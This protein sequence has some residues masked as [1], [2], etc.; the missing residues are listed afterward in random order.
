MKKNDGFTLVEL[1]LA[2][3]F[4][5]FILLFVTTGFVMVNRAYTKGLTVKQIQDE[6][7]RVME[8]LTRKV[9]V[10]SSEGINIFPSEDCIE[11]SGTIY[12][13]SIPIDSG[14]TESPSRLYEEDGG[15]CSS[16]NPANSVSMLN[17][18]VGV[19]FMEVVGVAGSNSVYSIKLVL[20]TSETDLITGDL[21][22]NA[23][24]GTG[25]GYQYCDVISFDTVVSVR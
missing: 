11:I 14:D 24:C 5:S 16:V 7:R 6:G 25:S 21:T 12:Y 20:S 2:M 19:Q 18:R 1:L 10:A 15:D 4:F 3:A 13:W 22:E 9:R 23:N 17:D 8:D